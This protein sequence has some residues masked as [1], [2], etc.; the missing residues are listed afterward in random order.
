MRGMPTGL[1]RGMSPLPPARVERDVVEP[2]RCRRSVEACVFL[3]VA[4]VRAVFGPLQFGSDR[5][6]V[7]A[8]RWI[9]VGSSR[10]RIGGLGVVDLVYSSFKWVRV[11]A[12]RVVEQAVTLQVGTLR[13]GY[14]YAGS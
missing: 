14:G 5:T 2:L 10:A 6:I 13:G 7:A 1:F 3:C 8:W 11:G 4:R 9:R 12:D